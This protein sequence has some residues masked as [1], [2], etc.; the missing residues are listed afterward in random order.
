MTAVCLLQV[1]LG[2]LRVYLSAIN[3]IIKYQNNSIFKKKISAPMIKKNI[4]NVYIFKIYY[5][6]ITFSYYITIMCYL[7]LGNSGD[8]KLIGHPLIF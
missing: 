8:D 6:Q 1:S 2:T 4:Y 3:F 7:S 5:K